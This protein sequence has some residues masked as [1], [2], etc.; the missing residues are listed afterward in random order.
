MPLEASICCVQ[1]RTGWIMCIGRL[2]ICNKKI[3]SAWALGIL[4][5]LVAIDAPPFTM[6][7]SMEPRPP[8]LPFFVFRLLEICTVG[9]FFSMNITHKRARHDGIA[10]AVDAHASCA[11]FTADSQVIY[12]PCTTDI[13]V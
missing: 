13:Y 8:R 9:V 1:V 6:L 7:Q 2:T 4:N 5:M 10:D 3:V 11:P 12:N